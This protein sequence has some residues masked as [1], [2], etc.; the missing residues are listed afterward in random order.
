MNQSF[1]RHHLELINLSNVYS[2]TFPCSFYLFFIILIVL[3]SFCFFLFV[4]IFFFSIPTKWENELL[5]NWV[6]KHP[7][8]CLPLTCNCYSLVWPAPTKRHSVTY[9]SM[10]VF[11][12]YARLNSHFQAELLILHY[13]DKIFSD[14]FS[15]VNNYG[16]HGTCLFDLS[17]R[18]L[19]FLFDWLKAWY[20]Y[21]SRNGEKSVSEFAWYKIWTY[22]NI[23]KIKCKHC[24][25]II[26]LY[27]A[28]IFFIIVTII[29]LHD[30]NTK[31]AL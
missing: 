17:R 6:Q 21:I 4:F 15:S 11:P 14:W 28:C 31:Q 30:M 23:K 24:G 7:L 25:V 29:K 26:L 12:Q 16:L 2:H 20:L 18:V 10:G 8:N 9:I 13:I 3:F 5:G 27:S 19:Q 1:H 22:N